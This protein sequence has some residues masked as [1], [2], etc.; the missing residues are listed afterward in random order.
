M[1][2]GF[3]TP[4]FLNVIYHLCSKIRLCS[5]DRRSFGE[6]NLG[7]TFLYFTAEKLKFFTIFVL[8]LREIAMESSKIR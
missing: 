1:L 2:D 6:E 4:Y 8:F 5:F 3:L 7:E